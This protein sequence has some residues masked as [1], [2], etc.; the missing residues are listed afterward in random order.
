[1]PTTDEDGLLAV[2][3]NIFS[4]NT[5]RT[6]SALM[7]GDIIA[8][9]W[10]LT[11]SWSQLSSAEIKTIS[12]A[13]NAQTYFPVKFPKP[14]TEDQYYTK[15]FLLN[16]DFSYPFSI[17]NENGTTFKGVTLNVVEQ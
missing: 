4:K 1:M 8:V 7:V 13:I 11:I 5:G 2:P 10:E 16:G 15:T 9:K 14:G 17:K 3:H 6:A 12:D